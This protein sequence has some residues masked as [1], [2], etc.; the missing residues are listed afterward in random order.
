LGMTTNGGISWIWQHPI[1][2]SRR[3]FM[4]MAFVNERTGW[5]VDNYG[6]ILHT[7]DG[8]ITW[9]PQTSGTYF[10]ITSVQFFDSQ[11]GWATATN[12]MVLHTTDAG[13]NWRT[14]YLD[15]LNYGTGVTV[16][17]EDIY[18]VS[19]SKGWVA[20]NSAASDTDFH[21]TPIVNTSDAGITWRCQNTSESDII[22]AIAF[23]DENVGWAASSAGILNTNDG[24]RHWTFQLQARG[25]LFVDMCF[26]GRTRGWAL[27]F[28]GNIY[29]F[30]A[31]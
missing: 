4:A 7:E 14:T 1:G 28:T 8:G 26:V 20:T 23:A 10:A 19:R 31:I 30:E 6:G 24:G 15:N 5:V 29:R 3:A 22:T 16:V 25:A 9:T 17:F 21:P 12:R 27:T 13:N 2:E 18:F 11:E